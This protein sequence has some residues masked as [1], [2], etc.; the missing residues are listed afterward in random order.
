MQ[1]DV[2]KETDVADIIKST[3]QK[4]GT[5]TILVNN[6]AI[7]GPIG[8]LVQND[9][10]QWV[11][12]MQ[13]NLFGTFLC[14]KYVLPVMISAGKGKIVNLSGG[15]VTAPRPGFSAYASSKSAVVGLTSTLAEEV[16]K[17]NIQVNAIAPGAIYSRMHEQVLESGTIAGEKEVSISRQAKETGGASIDNVKALSV[18]LASDDS[19]GLTGRLI[20]AAWDNLQTISRDKTAIMSS[21]IYT[22]KRI[23]NFMFLEAKN[24]GS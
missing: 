7:L 20:S 1:K 9:L 6:A 2:S 22:M 13:I 10:D 18:F 4:Y 17:F 14:C 24:R 12:T 5:I 21:S 19:D 3:V 16:K 15:G 11:K 23:D 8:P